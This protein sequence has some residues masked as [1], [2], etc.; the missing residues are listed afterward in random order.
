MVIIGTLTGLGLALLGVPYALLLG[1]LAALTELLP[2]LGPWISGSVSVVFSLIA[3]GPLK[4][5]EVVILFIL[6]QEIEGNVVEPLV[7]SRAVRID[8]LLVIVAVLIGLDLLGIIGAI[9][10]VPHSR[11]YP[12]HLRGSGGSGDSP[13][14]LGPGGE[15]AKD[16]QDRAAGGR[17]RWSGVS[18]RSGVRS[19]RGGGFGAARFGNLK[20]W[21]S[22]GSSRSSSL[23]LAGFGPV[24]L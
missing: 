21:V 1:L 6:I 23:G 4:A 13:H 20:R 12:G 11:R 15:A 17:A 3:V 10:A 22:L 2:Y 19:H 7:M 18:G 5:V 16:E 24:T 14:D 9:L 8:P